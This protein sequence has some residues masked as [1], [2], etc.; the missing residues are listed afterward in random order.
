MG[1]D[2]SYKIFFISDS[3]ATVDFGNVI[4]EEKNRR[5][6]A[7]FKHLTKY[8]LDGMIEAIPAYSSVTIYYDVP[9]LRK[10]LPQQRKVYDW[11]ENELHKLMRLD[12]SDIEPKANIVRIP[13]CYGNEFGPDLK[14]MAGK[15]NIPPEE[16]VRVHASKQYRVYMLGFLP[17]FAYMGELD[18]Q[19]AIPRKQQ[20]QPV[21]AGSVGIAGRQT[22]V[23]PL[24]SP[25]GWQ[26]IG[27][28]PAK[29]FDKNTEELCLLRAGD[30]VEFIAITKDE[31]ENYQGG[32]F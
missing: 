26:I 7:L 20:P 11:L 4:D 23:Y 2:T 6:I 12:F 17:G 21:L 3:A 30:Y 28:T 9:R 25:G 10:K 18:D 15:K 29:I 16:I 24:N 1:H 8:P 13:V 27:R 31:F 14:W 32:R 19:I 5:S 22:G